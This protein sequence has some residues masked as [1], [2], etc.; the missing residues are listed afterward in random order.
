MGCRSRST[1]R[2]AAHRP[3]RT[4]GGCGEL[5]AA[6]LRWG[7]GWTRHG[8]RTEGIPISVYRSGLPAGTPQP[9]E[10]R[11]PVA[12]PIRFVEA[13]AAGA[14][15]CLPPSPGSPCSPTRR[16]WPA[17]GPPSTTRSSRRRHCAAR[18]RCPCTAGAGRGRDGPVLRRPDGVAAVDVYEAPRVTQLVYL[19]LD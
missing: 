7:A 4:W 13:L 6:P 15:A 8:G 19:H 3:S 9:E 2:A 5:P 11:P 14:G 10:G 16:S 18:W 1:A 12:L 17:G